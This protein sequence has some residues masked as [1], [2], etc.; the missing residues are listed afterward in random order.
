VF[1]PIQSN[2]VSK[3]LRKQC[4]KML[5][6]MLLILS[7][8]LTFIALPAVELGKTKCPCFFQYHKWNT[9]MSSLINKF[10]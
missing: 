4:F 5:M 6:R 2:F 1:L 10:T 9:A 7:C 3:A 8:Y